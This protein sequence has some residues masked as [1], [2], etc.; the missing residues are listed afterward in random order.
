M[1][2]K[3]VCQ[4]SVAPEKPG[5]AAGAQRGPAGGWAGVRRE[6]L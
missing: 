3:P 4:D 1:P 6:R 5:H 2:G